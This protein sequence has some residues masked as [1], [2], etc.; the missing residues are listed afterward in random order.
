MAYADPCPHTF[1]VRDFCPGVTGTLECGEFTPSN[2]TANDPHGTCDH[3]YTEILP[4]RFI[5][6]YDEDHYGSCV[7]GPVLKCTKTYGCVVSLPNTLPAACASDGVEILSLTTTK[8]TYTEGPDC[9][10][11]SDST[12]KGSV[13]E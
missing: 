8:G 3:K 1:P 12:P 11:T 5:C 7:P 6:G 9:E 2:P 13:P 4:N 10:D